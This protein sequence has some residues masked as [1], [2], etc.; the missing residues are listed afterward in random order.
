MTTTTKTRTSTLRGCE[1]NTTVPSTS[2]G[3]RLCVLHCY[4]RHQA[5][6]RNGHQSPLQ[7]TVKG[8]KSTR[9]RSQI[10]TRASCPG[11]RYLSSDQ[12]FWMA[13]ENASKPQF[14]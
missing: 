7:G 6:K 10:S 9:P 11:K 4:K 14:A 1:G 2:S 8:P 3:D 5:P 12:S 13:Q